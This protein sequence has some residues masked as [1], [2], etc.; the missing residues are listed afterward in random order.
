MTRSE[1]F[2][3]V[4][5]LLGET[6]G[7]PVA[8]DEGMSVGDVDGWDSFAQITLVGLLED[9]FGVKFA[10][11]DVLRMTHVGAIVDAVAARLA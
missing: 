4:E 7:R 1:I 2:E 5:G 3:R 8:L 11:Q 9:A 10:M 6:L